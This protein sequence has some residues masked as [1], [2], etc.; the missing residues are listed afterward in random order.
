MFL[1]TYALPQ[2]HTSGQNPSH[3]GPILQR[4]AFFTSVSGKLCCKIGSTSTGTGSGTPLKK[5]A[6]GN[7]YEMLD[8]TTIEKLN[9]KTSKG[10]SF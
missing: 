3:E 10:M 8:G 1:E 7:H 2:P 4:N 9:Q 5:M 6:L